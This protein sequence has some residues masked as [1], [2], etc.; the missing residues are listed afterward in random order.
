MELPGPEPACECRDVETSPGRGPHPRRMSGWRWNANRPCAIA[1]T[2]LP[3]K[4]R[5]GAVPPAAGPR[6]L[7]PQQERARQPPSEPSASYDGV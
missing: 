2:P 5:P 3:K 4:Q 6:E 1:V 7:P